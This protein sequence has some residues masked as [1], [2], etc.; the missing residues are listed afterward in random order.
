M[1]K[2]RKIEIDDKMPVDYTGVCLFPRSVEKNEI[3][4]CIFTK[5]LL[6]LLLLT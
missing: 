4:S 3:W 1:G 6:K 5:A 2:E